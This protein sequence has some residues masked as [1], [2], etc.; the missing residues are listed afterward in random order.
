[1]ATIYVETEMKWC[2][3]QELLRRNPLVPVDYVMGSLL[4][5]YVV[6]NTQAGFFGHPK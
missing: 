4:D 5:Y 6:E 3:N 2:S 1:M